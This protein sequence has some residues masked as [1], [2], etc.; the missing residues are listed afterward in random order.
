MTKLTKWFGLFY[1]VLLQACQQQE[2]TYHFVAISP[3]DT[4]E[5]I[6]QKAVNVVPTK[7]QLDW[8]ENEFIAFIHFGVN[9][10]TAREW[11]TGKEEPSVFDPTDFDAR[12]WAKT[13]KA[14]GMKMAMITAKHHD[15]FCLWPSR[16]TEHSVKNSPW[17]NGQGDV[18]R[19]LSEACREFGLKL[20]IYLSPAD[21]HEIEREGGYYG[22]GSK[23]STRTIPSAKEHRASVKRTFDYELTDYDTY[24]MD[25]LYETLTEYG[26]IHELW[27]DGANPKPG[28]DQTYNYDAWYDLIRKLQPKAVIAIKGP[29]VR[30]C[31]N[32][33]GHTRA[34]E[35][36]VI[37][38]Q[39]HPDQSSF[40]DATANDLGSR[41]KLLDAKY[42][43]WYPAETNTSIR[44]G[45]FYRDEQQYVKTVTELVD[46]WYRSVGGNTVFLLNLTPDRRGLIPDTD[47]QRLREL[48]QMIESSFSHNLM[49]EADIDISIDVDCVTKRQYMIDANP[50]TYWIP[51]DGNEKATLTF[52]FPETQTFNRIVIQ[53]YIREKGQRIERFE[54][55][56]WSDE[57]WRLVAK[58]TTVGYKRILRFPAETT[59]KFRLRI[60]ESRIAPSISNLEVYMGEELLDVPTINRD[61][62]G[63]VSI[64]CSTPDPIIYYTLDGSEPSEKSLKY[65]GPFLMGS[66]GNIKARAF[67]SDHSRSTDVV[68]KAFDVPKSDWKVV[69][70]STPANGFEAEKAI[71]DNPGTMWHTPWGENVKNHPHEIAVDMGQTYQLK[72][73]VYQPRTDGN[74]SGT[75][76]TYQ[77]QVSTNGEKW[78]TVKAGTFDNIRNNPM[79]QEVLFTSSVSARYFRFI[80]RSGAADEPWVSVGEIG[81]ITR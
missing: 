9:T 71:D 46:T 29:D 4:P 5:S 25:Q 59:T 3:D 80:S 12:Q 22:N 75:V 55:D 69:S 61:K 57:K 50:E 41:E 31:G 77:F 52:Q 10:F 76:K 23:R 33:A 13:M 18:L 7:K 26:P 58:S 60:L 30:W 14:A 81:I 19:E 53:E 17:N 65:S 45:W 27:F 15:G 51:E 34:D 21:L 11:G 48:G 43:Y 42:L 40:K 67:T 32:E 74:V 2:A 64:K 73:F 68:S 72:G 78:N 56:V 79:L 28:T 44:H 20:G 37:P 47:A 6:V 54:V 38:L 24:F 35:W 49:T 66:P 39:E 36:S 63:M 70:A 1:L 62:S 16:Y 8:Q